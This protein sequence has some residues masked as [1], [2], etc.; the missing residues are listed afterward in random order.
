MNDISEPVDSFLVTTGVVSL[1][2]IA[3]CRTKNKGKI[4]WIYIPDA[5]AEGYV[6]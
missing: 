3:L 6:N 5:T 4:G 1:I 2:F